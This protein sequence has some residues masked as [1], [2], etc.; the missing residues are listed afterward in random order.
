MWTPYIIA[1]PGI[2]RGVRLTE[3]IDHVDQ[4][5]TILTALGVQVP[6]HIQG[7]RLTEALE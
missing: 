2:K 6:A 1:G 5:P 7:R 4:L 3:P